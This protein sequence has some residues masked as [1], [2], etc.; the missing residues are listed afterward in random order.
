MSRAFG[1]SVSG[2]ADNA[3]QVTKPFEIA[4][5]ELRELSHPQ[6]LVGECYVIHPVCETV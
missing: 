3:H 4:D 2:E 5:T 6:A 1:I